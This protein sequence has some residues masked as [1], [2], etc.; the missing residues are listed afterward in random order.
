M[1]WDRPVATVLRHQ[2]SG[3]SPSL[4]VAAFDLDWTLI[5]PERQLFSSD[6]TNM[7]L[8]PRVR[9][10]LQY[11]REQGYT[12]VIFTNQLCRNTRAELA[13]MQW[14]TAALELIN[15]PA[16]VLV[17]LAE[18]EY[19]KPNPGM[20]NLLPFPAGKEQSF[21]VGDA[22]GRPGDFADSDRVFAERLGIAFSTP[23]DFFPK[24]TLPVQPKRHLV[25]LMG[26]PGVGKTELY[27]TYYAP[28][29]YIHLNQDELKTRAKVLRSLQLALATGQNIVIDSTN[30][31]RAKRGEYLTLAA[32]AG[33]KTDIVFLTRC[34]TEYNKRRSRPVPQIAYS[35]YFKQLELPTAAEVTGSVY[36][37]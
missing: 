15:I 16:Y 18:D 27:R 25:L 37:L 13:K 5:R 26:M 6:P 19:R 21:Y 23:E 34:G 22:A 9:E 7:V 4:R 17:A 24:V 32:A 2:P 33:Y 12:I 8:M 30:P 35:M 3:E 14:I 1:S 29:G 10:T 36:E 20:W 11:L 31:G 28:R